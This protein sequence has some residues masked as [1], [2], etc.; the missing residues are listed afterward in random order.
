MEVL[1]EIGFDQTG[2]PVTAAPLGR[3]LGIFTDMDG[4]PQPLEDEI[5]PKEFERFFLQVTNRQDVS[6]AK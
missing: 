3:N 6:V 5:D 4:A 1:R 2:K